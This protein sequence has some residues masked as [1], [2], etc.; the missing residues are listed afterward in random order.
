MNKRDLSF[1]QV[2]TTMT[3]TSDC[4]GNKKG[5]VGICVDVYQIGG[6]H[7]YFF[8]FPNGGYDGFSREDIYKFMKVDSNGFAPE[9]S[10]Y[11]FSNVIKLS[12]D[13]ENGDFD[14]VFKYLEN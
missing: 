2:G 11:H 10:G 1:I 6:R 14:T 13:F 7:G 3:L 5:T 9:I 8:L 4:L 12:R